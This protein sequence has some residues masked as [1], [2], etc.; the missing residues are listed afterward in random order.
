[1]RI[2]RLLLPFGASVVSA[3]AA[4]TASNSYALVDSYDATNFLS[5]F[6][7]FTGADPTCGF[8]DYQ[9][10]SAANKSGIAGYVNGAVYLGVDHITKNPVGGR[11]SVRV[12]SN[13]AYTHGLIIADIPHM[14]GGICGTWPAFW[15]YGPNWPHSG[16][17]DIVEGVNAQSANA[18]TLHAAEGCSLDGTGSMASSKLASTACTPNDGC[19]M[20]TADPLNYGVAF[21]A[22]GGG[23]Y[24]MEWTSSFISVHFF[25]RGLIPADIKA[26]KPNPASWGA[27]VA[28]FSGSGCDIDSHFSQQSIVFNTD[29]CGQVSF[30]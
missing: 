1:M 13:K 17:I 27:P 16:E 10:K 19:K 9:E 7:F 22:A 26:G 18:V 24:A 5:E 4:K 28:R 25:S 15:T 6:S 23:V 20:Q 21:N 8:V 29:F 12:T 30:R 2:S 3:A 11:N 14:P